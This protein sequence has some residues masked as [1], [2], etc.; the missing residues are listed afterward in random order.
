LGILFDCCCHTDS[1]H[2]R[3]N[4]GQD[5]LLDIS[6]CTVPEVAALVNT[7]GGGRVGGVLWQV[8]RALQKADYSLNNVQLYSGWWTQFAGWLATSI[9]QDGHLDYGKCLIRVNGSFCFFYK[10]NSKGKFELLYKLECHN[11]ARAIRGDRNALCGLQEDGKNSGILH[12]GMKQQNEPSLVL[13]VVRKDRGDISKEDCLAILQ[14]VEEVAQATWNQGGIWA[15]FLLPTFESF[16]QKGSRV[17]A[18]NVQDEMAKAALEVTYEV[19]RPPSDD[20]MK[21]LGALLPEVEERIFTVKIQKLIPY[22]P[23]GGIWAAFRDEGLA[24]A[25]KSPITSGGGVPACGQ[26]CVGGYNPNTDVIFMQGGDAAY[27]KMA[28]GETPGRKLWEETVTK[29]WLDAWDR[30]KKLQKD[31]FA[32]SY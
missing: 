7:N 9:H 25:F 8:A 6:S 13:Q 14:I 15:S 2:W 3:P 5:F 23:A 1:S 11:T 17:P 19:N 20:K 27:R 18:R 21:R 4:L 32:H 24:E 31:V 10:E 26:I 22:S 30:G 28:S 29:E 12:A 16:L